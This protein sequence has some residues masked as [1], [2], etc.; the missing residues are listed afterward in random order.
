LRT[1]GLAFTAIPFGLAAGLLLGF[2]RAAHE[3]TLRLAANLI[4]SLLRGLPELL[5]ILLVYFMGQRLLN[6]AV[7]LVGGGT[8]QDIS[9][10]WSGVAA[11]GIVFAA[12][13][14]EV[15]LGSLKA[16]KASHLQAAAALGLGPFVTLRFV[17]LQEVFRLSAPGLSNLWLSLLK[18]TSLLSVIGYSDL[19][20]SGYVAASSTGERIFF[21]AVVFA[22][23][24]LL[25]AAGARLF[26][27]LIQSAS[28][29]LPAR[30]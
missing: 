15:F 4:S 28:A 16:L 27:W 11:L 9:I 1:I 29:K 5:T 20:R 14:S 19:L 17:T 10:F 23:Y 13:S 3:P 6:E 18:Q 12:Y 22:L 24:L 26:E 7:A 8:P 2:A 25:C 30:S 21:Y